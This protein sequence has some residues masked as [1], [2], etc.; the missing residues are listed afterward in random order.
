MLIDLHTHTKKIKTGDKPTREMPLDIKSALVFI[1]SRKSANV[2]IVAITNHNYFD[3]EQYELIKFHSNE[4]LILPG[5]EIDVLDS[6]GKN[7]HCN[8]IVD[9]KFK[10]KIIEKLPNDFSLL[11]NFKIKIDDFLTIVKELSA[12]GI[13][14]TMSKG[15]EFP[16]ADVEKILKFSDENTSSAILWEAS[17][18]RGAKIIAN[19]N[20]KPII[21]SDSDFWNVFNSHKLPEINIEIKDFKTFVL[22]LNKNPLF[23]GMKPTKTEIVIE[24][25]DGVEKWNEKIHLPI[26][27]GVNLIIGPKASGKSVILKSIFN[28]VKKKTQLPLEYYE[29]TKGY[30]KLEKAIIEELIT[31]NINVSDDFESVKKNLIK[32]KEINS[33]VL[34][35]KYL[36]LINHLQ[37]TKNARYQKIL[38]MKSNEFLWNN[39]I[40]ESGCKKINEK[41]TDIKKLNDAKEIIDK[42]K[43]TDNYFNTNKYL[44]KMIFEVQNKLLTSYI[45]IFKN[46]LIFKTKDV[47]KQTIVKNKSVTTMPGDLGISE[48]FSNRFSLKKSISKLLDNDYYKNGK[49]FL[50]NVVENSGNIKTIYIEMISCINDKDTKKKFKESKFNTLTVNV[51]IGEEFFKC[52]RNIGENIFDPK[53]MDKCNKLVAEI[54]ENSINANNLVVYSYLF[55]NEFGESSRPSSGEEEFLALSNYLNNVD[56]SYYFL[57]EPE[58][59]LDNKIIYDFI[60]EKINDIQARGKTVI[61]TTHN[62]NI[63]IATEPNFIILRQLN[64]KRPHK[65]FIGDHFSGELKLINGTEIIK[66]KDIALKILEGGNE[67]MKKRNEFYE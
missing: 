60:V 34:K 31:K 67:A 2:S 53:I 24:P 57:D 8:L 39:S 46:K 48:L 44:E 29:S 4:I 23:G 56:K 43:D 66:W 28:E 18:I 12:I 59:S 14:E 36:E 7:H 13:F 61:L 37:G 62:A 45:Q 47:F 32:S 65:T 1:E 49:K 11:E 58:K 22:F 20:R 38:D 55:T 21:G 41:V 10:K 35:G 6:E 50:G 51:K 19:Y 52:L 27:T 42:Y 25:Q 40:E 64:D 16:K 3:L 26:S 5:A 15:K 63:A 17:D 9:D 54:N 33:M 30:K